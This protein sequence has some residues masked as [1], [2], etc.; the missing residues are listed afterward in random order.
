MKMFLIKFMIYEIIQNKTVI[1]IVSHYIFPDGR[2]SC[3]SLYMFKE[4]TL[5]NKFLF[6]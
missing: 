4:K 2:I 5:T 3:I 1:K 6:K